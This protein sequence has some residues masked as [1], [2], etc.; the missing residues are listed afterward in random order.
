[1]VEDGGVDDKRVS[2]FQG[3]QIGV[4]RVA[5]DDG[6]RGEEFK[7]TLLDLVKRGGD[8]S[9]FF[10]SNARVPRRRF[11]SIDLLQCPGCSRSHTASDSQR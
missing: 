7:K 8:C 11:V 9:K 6:T 10:R 1:M 4:C 2:E 5:D 3:G